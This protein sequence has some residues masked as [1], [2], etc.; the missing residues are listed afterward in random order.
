MKKR[1]G[2]VI[3]LL[4]ICLNFSACGT[5]K[6]EDVESKIDAI[7]KVSIDSESAIISAETAFAALKP[8]E[9]AKVANSGKL[10]EARSEFDKEKRMSKFVDY[11]S[12][13]APIDILNESETG[14]KI[15]AFSNNTIEMIYTY[16][17]KKEYNGSSISSN[18]LTVTFC[19]PVGGKTATITESGY[20]V[21]SSISS[22]EHAEGTWNISEYSSNNTATTWT[23]NG[24]TWYLNGEYLK[25]SESV[26]A[27]T[28]YDV[29]SQTLQLVVSCLEI[30]AEDSGTGVTLYDLGFLSY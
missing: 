12:Q 28:K 10:V 14:L 17:S 26:F 29:L 30:V 3:V 5:K 22:E 19:I 20:S 21:E 2:C 16:E 6:I 9:Q 23:S 13:S 7:G 4:A 25:N 11:L 18:E 27:S 15:S 8:D 24:S 1:L